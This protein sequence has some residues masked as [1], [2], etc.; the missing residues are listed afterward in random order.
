MDTHVNA[1]RIL[2]ACIVKKVSCRMEEGREGGKE[3]GGRGRKGGGREPESSCLCP[4]IWVLP[5]IH[6]TGIQRCRK[7][8]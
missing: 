6:A 5:W 1:H 3:R 8:G 2:L 4:S 7:L